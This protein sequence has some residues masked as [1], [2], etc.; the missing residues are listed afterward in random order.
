MR[1][2]VGGAH[3]Y[4]Y[5]NKVTF[6]ASAAAWEPPPDAYHRHYRYRSA[7]TQGVQGG[8]GAE[9]GLV[10]AGVACQGVGE[11][12]CGEGVGAGCAERHGWGES[13]VAE[14]GGGQAQGCLQ[15]VPAEGEGGRVVLR[16]GGCRIRGEAGAHV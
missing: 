3:Q 11:D 10:A 13:V 14:A 4:G 5:R 15:E 12:G 16:W 8:Q 9:G 2:A 6:T 1:P 7:S